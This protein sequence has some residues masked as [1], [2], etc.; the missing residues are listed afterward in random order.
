VTPKDVSDLAGYPFLERTPRTLTAE[1]LASCSAEILPPDSVLLS[2]RAP[3]GL[4]AINHM[5]VA[6]NQGFKSFVP[7]ATRLDAGF[8]YHW[9]RANRTFLERLGA[10]A[11]FK[12]VSKAVISRIEIPLPPL[13]E[14]KRI[15]AVLS[16]AD[17]LLRNR[18]ESFRFT[19]KL[20]QSVFIDM[21]GDLATNPKTWPQNSLENLCGRIVDCPHSTPVYSDTP[22]AFYC[23][24]SAEI[25]NG[26]IDLSSARYVSEEVFSERIARHEPTAG[27]VIY[28]REGGRLGYAAQVPKGR[29]ICLG[30]RMMLFSAEKTVASNSFLNGLLNSES[31]RNRVLNLV[32]GGA[33]PRVNIKDLRAIPVYCPPIELQAR[34]EQFATVLAEQEET[35]TDS[36]AHLSSLFFS[37]QQRAFRGELDL[38]RLTLDSPENTLSIVLPEKA[39]AKFTNSKGVSLLFQPPE[40]IEAALNVLDVAVTKG[41]PIPWSG[42]Y[43]KYRLLGV[44]S[45]PFT[46][47]EVMQKADSV[48]DAPPYEEIKDMILELLGQGGGPAIL[49]QGFDLQ[50]DEN[51]KEASGRKEIVFGPAA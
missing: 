50:I 51:T 17:T 10:G 48:F 49:T 40:A 26:K 2:S 6:T 19:E 23:V 24:R 33:A 30:Q 27:E 7:D 1:G 35:V 14:Q 37:I 38:S 21:F 43:F 29:R 39:A 4:V 5:P 31:F 18:R 20:L 47:A 3:I 41:E 11:T 44:Q 8:L 46:F 32:G 9:L 36:E 25:Q 42:D 15:A 45:A 13:A 22:T 16:K 12:E 28:T 34:Y